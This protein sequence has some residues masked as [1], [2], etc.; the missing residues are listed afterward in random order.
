MSQ[1]TPSQGHRLFVLSCL[2]NVCEPLCDTPLLSIT[3]MLEASS[4][5]NPLAGMISRQSA[6]F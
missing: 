1:Y 5:T 4:L 2:R 6:Q 3:L